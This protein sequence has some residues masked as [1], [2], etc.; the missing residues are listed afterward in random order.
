MIQEWTSLK[1]ATEMDTGKDMST[2]MD[3]ERTYQQIATEMDTVYRT[4]LETSIA[5]VL[6]SDNTVFTGNYGD[7]YKGG[8]IYRQLQQRMQGR[9]QDNICTVQY[10]NRRVVIS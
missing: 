3:T 2:E 4:H 6:Y 9:S 8:L 1:I 7:E 5:W 10:V